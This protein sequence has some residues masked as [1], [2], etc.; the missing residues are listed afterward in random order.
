MWPFYSDDEPKQERAATDIGSVAS[1][2]EIVKARSEAASRNRIANI[3][4]GLADLFGGSGNAP[5]NATFFNNLRAQNNATV[6]AA[7]EDR[8]NRIKNFMLDQQAREFSSQ[9]ALA[10]P[11]S[12][13]SAAVRATYAKM[14]PDAVSAIGSDW[15]NMSADDIKGNLSNLM[16]MR[17]RTDERKQASAERA[18]DR[19]AS[20]AEKQD[21]AIAEK[22]L[23][24]TDIEKVG[25]A[26]DAI[27][28][29]T[30]LENTISSQSASMGPVVGRFKTWNPYDTEAQV[31][32]SK[33]KAAAQMIGKYLEGGVLRAE[34]VPKYEAMLPT[35]K[36]TPEVAKGKLNNVRSQLEQ[37]QKSHM[38]ALGAQGYSVAGLAKPKIE[39]NVGPE[40]KSGVAYAAEPDVEAYAKAHG[41]TYENAKK[42]KDA[43]GGR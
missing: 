33:V 30:D 21:K 27:D 35:M 40:A 5:S 8:Q 32:Q 19:A 6:T 29:L 34:D 39:K 1:L 28:T 3:G 38:E 17:A 20:R 41:I 15:E 25:E 22:T 16:E 37:R 43:R 2:D 18:A 26:R 24:P 31:A 11:K 42:I 9:N 13:Q 14:F 4:H 36:D 7:E 10:D 12:A 23:K